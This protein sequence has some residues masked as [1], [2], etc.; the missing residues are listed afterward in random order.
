MLY[1]TVLSGAEEMIQMYNHS[2]NPGPYTFL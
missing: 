2:F 1:E